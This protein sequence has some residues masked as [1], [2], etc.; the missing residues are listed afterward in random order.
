[1]QCD[2]TLNKVSDMIARI[3]NHVNTENL[4]KVGLYYTFKKLRFPFTVPENICESE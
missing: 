2:L 4:K 3:G 1:M